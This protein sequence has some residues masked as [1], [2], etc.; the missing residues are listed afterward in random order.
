MRAMLTVLVLLAAATVS[1]A[2]APRWS[3]Q[4]PQAK[5]LPTGDLQW[6]PK[7]FEFRPGASVRY[8][9]FAAG[10]DANDGLSKQ[11][12]WKHHPWDPNA[13][14]NAKACSGVHTYVF[15]QGVVYRGE[16][17]A[18]ESGAES[19]PIIL[20]RDPTW[21]SGPAVICGSEKVGGWHAGRRQRAD[22]GAS[23]GLVR[24]S[25][26]GPALRLDGRPRRRRHPRS[27]R[28]HAELDDHRPG[29]HQE[30]VVDL[31]E[32]GQ[33]VR[34]LRHGQRPA[35]PPG[36]RQ[37]GTSTTSQPGGLLQGRPRLDHQ[38]LGDGQPVPGARPGRRPP[39]R[40]ADLP[41]PVGRRTLLQDHPRLPLL[42]GG[43]AAVPGQPR[44]VLVRQEGRRRP[45]LHPPA[46]RPGPEHR[47]RRG[48][49]AHPHDREP[50]HEPRAH[51]RPDLRVHQRLLEPAGRALLGQPRDPRRG[52]RL[53]APAGQRHGH[54]RDQLHL[55]ARPPRRAHEGHGRA[56]RHRQGGG[57][58]QRLQR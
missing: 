50:R 4:E 37:G 33:A 14:G 18:D 6:A 3:W 49:Q 28:P 13:T 47:R 7:P 23:E 36:V 32:P 44:R 27:A 31:E 35:A 22:P 34:Q 42:P 5:V 40:L 51:Q 26:V 17:N 12:A 30:P 45:A 53:R 25:G 48:G 56:G 38:G 20:T 55:R 41:G 52:A 39:E 57:G 24:R 54:R 58:R 10:N 16:M 8:I 43:Q 9:D 19:N 15:K 46:R 1:A 29:R 21:G 11:T 2:E